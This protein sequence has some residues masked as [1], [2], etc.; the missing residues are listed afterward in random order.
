MGPLSI[1]SAKRFIGLMTMSAIEFS[2]GLGRPNQGR[3][4]IKA[5]QV[6]GG[7]QDPALAAMPKWKRA[8][9]IACTLTSLP[10]ILPLLALAALWVRCV[11][12]GPVIFRQERIGINGKRFLMYKFRS[13]QI[14][15]SPTPHEEYTRNI[16]QS[17]RPWVKLDGLDDPRII[18]G[19]LLLRASGLDELPQL[20]NVLCGEMSLVGPRP[21]LAHEYDLQSP[22]Q[23]ARFSVLPGMTGSWQ[24]N[25]DNHTTFRQMN[26]MDL[27]YINHT[28]LKNDL[29]IILRTPA[30]L[31]DRISRARSRKAVSERHAKRRSAGAKVALPELN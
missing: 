30:I 4:R 14:K 10:L 13:M 20:I 5:A 7:R 29:V 19:G 11:S 25:Q 1:I 6:N 3:Q 2:S 27:Q 15:A 17:D 16:I 12:R 18:P 28:S 31:A 24:V 21:C 23:R 9:D 22:S 8:L 26:E